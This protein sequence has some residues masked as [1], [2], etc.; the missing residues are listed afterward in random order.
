MLGDAYNQIDDV[1]HAREAWTKA[2]GY[3]ESQKSADQRLN[4][5]GH[6]KMTTQQQKKK[7]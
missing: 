1:A 4:L 6:V 2:K 5:G 7:N 3:P